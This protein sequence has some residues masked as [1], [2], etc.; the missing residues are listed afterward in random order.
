MGRTG[1]A[2]LACA[3]LAAASTSA[4]AADAVRVGWIPAIVSSPLIIAQ[5]KGYFAD[6]GVKVEL[7]PMQTASAGMP[8]L[9][10]N[11][12]QILEG[13][14]QVSLFNGI[15]HGLPI[16]IA[17]DRASSPLGHV[18]L[19]RPDLANRVKG[20]KDLKGL[21]IATNATGSVLSYETDRLLQT[22]GLSLKDVKIKVVGFSQL[23]SA[24]ANKAVDAG[25]TFTPISY[26]L[27]AKGLAV[28]FMKTDDVLPSMEVAVTLMNTDWAKQ[29]PEMGR[30]FFLALGRGTRDFC[31]AYHNGPN[32]KEISDILL[33]TGI[34][35]KPETLDQFWGSRTAT[36]KV[37]I[38]AIRDIL[39]WYRSQG[40]VPADI[41][42]SKLVDSS[43]VDYA[44]KKLGPFEIE[45]KNDRT[46]GCK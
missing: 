1:S 4:R 9:A 27:P 15:L 31:Q 11:R 17:G 39:S 36:G 29:N 42:D 44:L 38:A 19:V 6:A 37:N 13:G 22:V 28:P 46:P 20:L 16:V 24:F 33:R 40:L 8:L 5:E 25:I 14:L 18:F 12:V 45:N 3:F 30:A 7:S 26:E 34:A 41:P 35:D 2:F 10:T 43:F 21:S 23:G 32:R